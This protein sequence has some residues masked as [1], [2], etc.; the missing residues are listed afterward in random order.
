MGQF[1]N[2]VKSARLEGQKALMSRS[3]GQESLE[4]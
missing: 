2:S 3:R 1:Q 4:I